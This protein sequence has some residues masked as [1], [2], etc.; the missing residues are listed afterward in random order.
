MNY[1]SDFCADV[2]SIVLYIQT[3]G[4]Y[5]DLAKLQQKRIQNMVDYEQEQRVKQKR[6]QNI[7]DYEQEQRVKQ[8]RIQNIVDYEQEQ[9]VKQKRI[10]NIVDY[11]QEQRVKLEDK[12]KDKKQDILESQA[13]KSLHQV[14]G[15]KDKNV[16]GICVSVLQMIVAI[17][18]QIWCLKPTYLS[19]KNKQTYEQ[20]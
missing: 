12:N 2:D 5:L 19:G 8:K 13:K 15:R 20:F 14:A 16:N 9:R 7:V 1:D 17:R 18:R 10:Q 11:E 4:E 3:C 6:I